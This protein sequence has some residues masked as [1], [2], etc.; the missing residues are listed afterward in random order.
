M[1]H[2]LI[3]SLRPGWAYMVLAAMMFT[4]CGPQ[5]NRITERVSEPASV[6]V[7]RE[8]SEET[9]VNQQ[10][11]AAVPDGIDE[12]YTQ[13][14]TPEMLNAL[15]A[16]TEV[17]AAIKDRD[18][19]SLAEYIHPDKG[20][21]FSPDAFVDFHEDPV[22]TTDQIRRF[23][24]DDF[25]YN[26]G[27]DDQSEWPVRMSVQEYFDR[28]VYDKDYLSGSQIGINHII[29]SGNCPD[30]AAEAFPDGIFVD[31]HDEGTEFYEGLDW[32]SLK[33]VME[34]YDDTY[35]AVAIIHSDYTL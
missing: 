30:N 11:C 31:Y 24:S 33:I 15:K 13:E 4:A 20:V 9:L 8:Q 3:R 28:Y 18:Y 23:G 22:F 7:S 35:K 14:Y 17:L 12:E 26:W 29:R 10:A 2:R 32:S 1:R 27:Y 5:T 16:A 21:V 25:I 6:S 34:T 19:E